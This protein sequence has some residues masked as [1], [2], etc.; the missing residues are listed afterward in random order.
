MDATVDSSPSGGAGRFESSQLINVLK[1]RNA[2]VA[3]RE[4]IHSLKGL[5]KDISG[6]RRS[7]NFVSAEDLRLEDE[8]FEVDFSL[9]Q[10]PTSKSSVA[11]ALDDALSTLR[12]SRSKEREAAA[13]VLYTLQRQ[14][15]GNYLSGHTP[16][17]NGAQSLPL[18]LDNESSDVKKRRAVSENEV[19]LKLAVHLSQS[20]SYV[21]EEWLVLGSTPICALRDALYC[22]MDENVRNVETYYNNMKELEGSD[23]KSIYDRGAYL[24][25]EGT[26]FEDR[27]HN[28]EEDL[29]K[30]VIEYL[31]RQSALSVNQELHKDQSQ[32]DDLFNIAP[33]EDH[34]FNDLE[35][36]LGPSTPG[37][38]C[39]QRCCEHLVVF[40]D[41][42]LHNPLSDPKFVDQ[43]PF[44]VC[45]PGVI[46][47]HRRQCE[48]CESVS[49]SKITYEDIRTPHSPFYWCEECFNKM[50]YSSEGNLIYSDFKVFPYKHG[51]QSTLLHSGR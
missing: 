49:A 17:R 9:K 4:E 22:L 7:T 8:M 10:G 43:Y 36:R 31:K 37:L 50:H 48:V 5:K 32:E 21:S 41:L 35:I 33:M 24:Y 39:H 2:A 44:K 40:K 20:P 34:C 38:F 26:F 6:R 45:S 1:F 19:I 13:K 42:R 23:K 14:E 51:Y 27:R 3:L 25:V 46:L 18:Q 47:E 12:E 28:P 11:K 15:E 29:S 30:T 16:G